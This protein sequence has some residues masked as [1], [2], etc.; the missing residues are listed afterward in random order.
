MIS[1]KDLQL[2]ESIARNNPRFREWLSSELEQRI[3]VL[4]NVTDTDQLRRAQGY[5]QCLMSLIGH[6][7]DSVNPPRQRAGQST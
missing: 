4:I 7:D 6:L 5:A 1:N 2:F 3:K